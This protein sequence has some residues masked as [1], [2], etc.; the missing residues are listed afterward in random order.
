MGIRREIMWTYSGILIEKNESRLFVYASDPDELF[1]FSDE[2]GPRPDVKKVMLDREDGLYQCIVGYGDGSN[3]IIYS[4]KKIV[5]IKWDEPEE[6]KVAEPP[7]GIK[8][9][10]LRDKIDVEILHKEIEKHLGG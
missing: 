1:E 8:V 4:C 10:P 9:I 2:T 6:I 5:N 7:K 3:P